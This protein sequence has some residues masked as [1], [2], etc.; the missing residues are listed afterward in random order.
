MK[1]TAVL[2]DPLAPLSYGFW[3]SFG[4]VALILYLHAG[5]LDGHGPTALALRLQAL[6]VD[7]GAKV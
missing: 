6:G 4:A 1:V 3:L 2:G 7:E 5:R